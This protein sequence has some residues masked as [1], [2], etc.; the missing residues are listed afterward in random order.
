MV[1]K[2]TVLVFDLDGT[3]IDRNS[4]LHKF[5]SEI[6]EYYKKNYSLNCDVQIFRDLLIQKDARGSVSKK[7]VYT[8]LAEYFNISD[9]DFD[10]FFKF[11]QD[12]F[13]KYNV[14][15]PSA[16][17]ALDYLKNQNYKLSLIS[18]GSKTQMDKLKLLK[19][20]SY[21]EFILISEPF[22][23][24]KPDIRI[25]EAMKNNYQPQNL[26]NFIYIGD[27]MKKDIVASKKAGYKTVWISDV[28]E[29][30]KSLEAQPDL[31]IKNISDFHL[32]NFD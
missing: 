25:F 8:A 23:V 30:D 27:D 18:N 7:K 1:K 22:G 4:S 17:K 16:L 19:L 11:Y 21:F 14:L 15:F 28:R 5:S 6:Y 12:N 32:I 10:S 26:F 31:S 2:Q 20:K 29:W 9:F 13:Y 3:L 24:E